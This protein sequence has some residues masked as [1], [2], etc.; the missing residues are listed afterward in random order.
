MMIDLNKLPSPITLGWLEK[1]APN[2]FEEVVRMPIKERLH[3]LYWLDS[4]STSPPARG[5]ADVELD[6]EDG[7]ASSLYTKFF[8]DFES[9]FV[10]GEGGYK[11]HYMTPKQIA[12]FFNNREDQR[13]RVKEKVRKEK[14]DR[15]VLAIDR[16]TKVLGFLRAHE[17]VTEKLE[18]RMAA[19]DDIFVR[20]KP[21]KG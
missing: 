20:E 21:M 11:I 17:I 2:T 18:Q 5:Y 19:N 15:A 7:T 8:I 9:D 6:K 13:S 4:K 10:A 3:L 12:N 1:N 14:E 16:A